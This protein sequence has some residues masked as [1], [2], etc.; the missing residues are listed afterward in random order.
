MKFFKKFIQKCKCE[1]EYRNIDTDYHV[2]PNYETR[3]ID[4]TIYYILYCPKCDKEKRVNAEKYDRG[5]TKKRLRKDY[6]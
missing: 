5:L 1:H 3:Q 2:Y 6:I 4:M